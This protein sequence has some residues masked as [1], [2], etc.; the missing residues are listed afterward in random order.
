MNKKLFPVKYLKDAGLEFFNDDSK[1][2]IL[3]D[4]DKKSIVEASVIKLKIWLYLFIL[5]YWDRNGGFARIKAQVLNWIGFDEVS[6]VDNPV[7]LQCLVL[8]SNIHKIIVVIFAGT[9]DTGKGKNETKKDWKVNLKIKHKHFNQIF[10]KLVTMFPEDFGGLVMPGKCGEGH[11]GYT[12]S[13]ITAFPDIWPLVRKYIKKGYSLS[14]GGHSKGGGEAVNFTYMLVKLLGVPVRECI[15]IGQPRVLDKT[16][17]T[18]FNKLVKHYRIINPGDPIPKTPSG[19]TYDH[20]NTRYILALKGV[21]AAKYGGKEF[22]SNLGRRAL[23]LLR[24]NFLW[25]TGQHYADIY[26]KRLNKIYKKFNTEIE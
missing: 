1:R 20:T 2:K 7:G 15:T 18:E 14:T 8:A 26:L 22:A 11:M 6:K 4:A 9:G 23:N 5:S 3:K 25:G 17:A 21:I 19:I 13:V 12:H 24:F 10:V 16:A